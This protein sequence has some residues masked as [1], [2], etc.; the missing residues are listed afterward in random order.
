VRAAV[1]GLASA[2][3][4]IGEA[5]R[6]EKREPLVAMGDL[7]IAADTAAQQHA[8]NPNDTAARDDYNFAVS[9]VFGC[10]TAARSVD[11]AAARAGGGRRIRARLLRPH[12]F[13]E[14]GALRFRRRISST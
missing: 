13:T 8:R 1:G 14:P 10:Q 6:R 4:N 5:M 7:L 12:K 2:E 3:Q 9:R 11:A